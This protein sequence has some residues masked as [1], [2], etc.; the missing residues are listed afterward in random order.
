VFVIS[1]GNEGGLTPSVSTGRFQIL[2]LFG[3]IIWV[4]ICSDRVLF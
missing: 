2:V 4:L 3:P 1:I